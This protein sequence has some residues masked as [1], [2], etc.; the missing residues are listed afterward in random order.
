M[1]RR[2]SVITHISAYDN[3]ELP[4]ID[5]DIGDNSL[6]DGFNSLSQSSHS[7]MNDSDGEV[8]SQEY[9][10]HKESDPVTLR[11]KH[12]IQEY[13]RKH[14]ELPKSCNILDFVTL[15]PTLGEIQYIN[16]VISLYEIGKEN[17]RIKNYL[18]A[19]IYFDTIITS[20]LRHNFHCDAFHDVF[21]LSELY[22]EL[23]E[24]HVELNQLNTAIKFAVEFLSEFPET[25]NAYYIT[26]YCYRK[27]SE[28]HN[29]L[30][31]CNKGISKFPSS[32]ILY[33]L[34]GK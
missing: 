15:N 28:Y 17:K 29:A 18:E 19:E 1:I 20:I 34:R 13:S 23:I 4:N 30:D 3:D 5:G 26:A 33:S 14:K 6:K 12:S 32:A 10:H 7:D 8:S 25:L 2:P 11:N 9:K 16:D 24:C 27:K 31:I 21:E 22:K